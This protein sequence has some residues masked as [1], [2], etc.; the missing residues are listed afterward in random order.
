[1]CTIALIPGQQGSLILAGNRDEQRSRKRALPPT[2]HTKKDAPY[3]ALYPVDANAFGTWIGLNPQ[4]LVITLLNN[5]QASATFDTHDHTPRSRGL[6]IPELL[7]HAASL[8]DAKNH[9]AHAIKPH[10]PY[11]FPFILILGHA[12]TPDRALRVTWSGQHLDIQDISTPHIEISS[13]FELDKVTQSRTQALQELLSI[14]DWTT[15]TTLAKTPDYITTLFADGAPTPTPYSVTMSRPEAHTVSH[16]RLIITPQQSS[17]TYI[18][19]P[20]FNLSSRAITTL[21]YP[22]FM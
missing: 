9:F 1:M 22:T 8:E 4:G 15:H 16:S 13:G 6:I 12:H 20:P 3:T 19:G 14:K 5:Y 17:I 18:D 21:H 2:L 7:H 11:T 10:L